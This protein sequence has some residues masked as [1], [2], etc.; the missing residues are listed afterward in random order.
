MHAVSPRWNAKIEQKLFDSEAYF[1][2]ACPKN[3]SEVRIAVS[4]E[5]MIIDIGGGIDD[6]T[7]C[8]RIEGCRRGEPIGWN[9]RKQSNGFARRRGR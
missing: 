9:F 7:A 4:L 3:E 8:T 5:S 2:V 1:R 6:N